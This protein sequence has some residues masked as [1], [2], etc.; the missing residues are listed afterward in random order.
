VRVCRWSGRSGLVSAGADSTKFRE[1]LLT[2]LAGVLGTHLCAAMRGLAPCGPATAYPARR[3][4]EAGVHG[5][6]CV[7]RP[8]DAQRVSRVPWVLMSMYGTERL[9]PLPKR[10]P[11]GMFAACCLLS[12]CHLA[13]QNA[14]TDERSATL[15][16]GQMSHCV[17][18]VHSLFCA[19]AN[20]G[21]SKGAAACRPRSTLFCRCIAGV[22]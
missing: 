18:E 13:C 10:N 7:P 17:Q 4:R 1:S 19:S 11:Q 12:A 22:A 9:M 15:G 6:A 8:V 5:A 2:R 21:C 3:A 14:C 20:C 16:Q